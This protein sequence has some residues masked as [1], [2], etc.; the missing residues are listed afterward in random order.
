[1]KATPDLVL[2]DISMPPW[3]YT[4]RVSD[5]AGRSGHRA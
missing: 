3:T 2:C 4:L 1:M 5:R